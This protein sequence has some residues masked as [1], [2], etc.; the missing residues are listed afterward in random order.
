MGKGLDNFIAR[1]KEKYPQIKYISG[2]VHAKAPATFKCL[3]CGDVYTRQP[4]LVLNKNHP[5]L[6]CGRKQNI[7]GYQEAI[8]AKNRA[9][10]KPVERK[11]KIKCLASL[12]NGIFEF[13]CL[14]C[15][16]TWQAYA[17]NVVK[18]KHGCRVCA[19]NHLAEVASKQ[20]RKEVQPE[21]NNYISGFGSLTRGIFTCNCGVQTP[22]T[23][24]VARRHQLR[25]VHPCRVCSIISRANKTLAATYRRKRMK[26]RG[27]TFNLQG[28]EPQALRWLIDHK[29]FSVK[30]IENVSTLETFPIIDY[31]DNRRKRKHIADFLV[32]GKHLVEVKSKF[33]LGLI[34]N[35]ELFKTAQAKARYAEKSGYRYHLLLCDSK[36]RVYELP[37]GWYRMRFNTLVSIVN[38]QNILRS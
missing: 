31:I 11:L 18:A 23:M 36:G 13:N 16:H 35:P 15:N 7:Q 19:N 17:K 28:Y 34:N 22:M 20:Y 27:K 38:Q 1:L 30:S 5:C 24:T 6:T 37:D 32:K 4:T 26:V 10:L 33:T 12:G 25:Q 8:E 14:T 29:G 3:D 9:R 2:W 21:I